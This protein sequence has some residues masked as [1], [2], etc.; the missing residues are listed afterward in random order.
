MA[1]S[2]WRQALL[3]VDAQLREDPL[4]LVLK[5]AVRLGVV[6][7]F[8]TPLVVTVSTIFPIMRT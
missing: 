7:L 5:W 1:M 8:F 6:L 4:T 2:S 3:F